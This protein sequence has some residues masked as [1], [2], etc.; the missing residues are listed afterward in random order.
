MDWKNTIDERDLN[1]ARLSDMGKRVG[2][3][4]SPALLII[5]AQY[6]FVGLNAPIEES[7]K[8]YRRSIGEE[9]WTAA[10]Q[11]G[12][13]LRAARGA[14]LPVYYSQQWNPE[15]ERRFDSF[16]RKQALTG[17]VK[18]REDQPNPEDIMKEIAPRRDE[19]V[20]KKRYASIFSGTPVSSFLVKDGVDTLIVCGYVTSGCVRG[21]VVDGHAHCYRNI[22]VADA[23]ADRFHSSHNVSLFDMDMK[24][25]DVVTTD[26]A[27]KW[28]KGKKSVKRAGKQL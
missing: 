11:I 2:W 21:T 23:C 3:G 16:A 8:V 20:I 5:D 28:L 1:V 14:G 17:T 24:Y 7:V 13:L 19:I 25:A 6:D 9:A 10:K 15:G 26:E 12:R 4:K 22:V 18:R 27:V